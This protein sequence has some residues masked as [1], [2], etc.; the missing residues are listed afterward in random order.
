MYQALYNNQVVMTS[1]SSIALYIS[2][3][4]SPLLGGTH[5]VYKYIHGNMGDFLGYR[6]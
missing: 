5:S 4:H 2:A 6:I 1:A 3:N